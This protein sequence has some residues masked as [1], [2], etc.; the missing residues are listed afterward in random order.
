MSL[1]ALP[2]TPFQ[3]YINTSNANLERL[4]YDDIFE[5]VWG[6]C[7]LN[8]AKTCQ[9]TRSIWISK[10]NKSLCQMWDSENSNLI[11]TR[12]RDYIKS[13]TKTRTSKH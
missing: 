10:N 3:P 6:F 11:E 8:T 13:A 12:C 4:L 2:S 7:H 1:A 5:E 9:K